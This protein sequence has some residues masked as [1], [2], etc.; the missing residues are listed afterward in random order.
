MPGAAVYT[1]GMVHLMRSMWRRFTSE[2]PALAFVALAAVAPV[3]AMG[4]DFGDPVAGRK[5]AE[6]WCSTCHLVH[7]GKLGTVT[8]A[9]TFASI[10]ANRENSGL[11]MR[12]FLRTPHERMPDL[13]LS[14]GETDDLIA[15]ILSPRRR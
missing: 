14:N 2:A 5:L 3:S 10:A 15:F 1:S 12:V 4:Q 11:A 6:A 13:Q 7:D 9:P 8:G